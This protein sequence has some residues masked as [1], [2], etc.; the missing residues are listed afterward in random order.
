MNIEWLKGY[1]AGVK[2]QRKKDLESFAKCI[3]ELNVKGI[4][5]EL[6]R[7]IIQT[8]NERVGEK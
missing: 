5:T 1:D 3:E 4:G 2:A 7:R 8:I 6:K